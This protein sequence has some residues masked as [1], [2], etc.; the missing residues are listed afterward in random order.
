[1]DPYM[2]DKEED[3]HLAQKYDYQEEVESNFIEF[4]ENIISELL[5]FNCI[6]ENLDEIL[7]HHFVFG[8]EDLKVVYEKYRF[9]IDVSNE[10]FCDA[11]CRFSD[12]NRELIYKNVDKFVKKEAC[13]IITYFDLKEVL[14]NVK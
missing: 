7:K 13:Y 12:K 1:M 14:F 4:R 3:L 8:A 11:G 10:F 9:E 6:I 5:S 2:K